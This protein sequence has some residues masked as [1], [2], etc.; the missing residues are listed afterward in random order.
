MMKLC[1][2]FHGLKVVRPPPDPPEGCVDVQMGCVENLLTR[3]R[4]G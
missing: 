1:R 3:Q 4:L 2:T